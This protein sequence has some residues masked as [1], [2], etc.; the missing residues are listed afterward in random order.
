MLKEE[1]IKQ[2]AIA[3]FATTELN[4]HPDIDKP[5][6]PAPNNESRPFVCISESDLEVVFSELT[7]QQ[8]PEGSYQRVELT[9]YIENGFGKFNSGCYLNDA[10]CLYKGPKDAFCN[11]AK[12]AD[13]ITGARPFV[14][15]SGMDL[16]QAAIAAHAKSVSVKHPEILN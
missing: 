11:A 10:R 9:D 1:D 2:G 3:Y 5:E 16:V 15:S 4:N 6:Y 14:N 8:R 12:N 13:K 7:S